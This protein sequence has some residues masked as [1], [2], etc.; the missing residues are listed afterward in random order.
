M[1]RGTRFSPLAIAVLLL[2]AC[3]TRPLI[4]VENTNLSVPGN[5]DVT[6]AEVEKAIYRGAVDKGWT[7]R[8]LAPG[9]LEAKIEIRT[10]MALVRIVHDTKTFSITYKDSR[11][12]GYDGTLIRRNYKRW[13][14]NLKQSILRQAVR[15]E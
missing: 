11:N 3:T 1:H 9:R 6:L 14:R 7:V 2:A 12:L 4:N 5:R 8:H 15:L 10:H 13:V